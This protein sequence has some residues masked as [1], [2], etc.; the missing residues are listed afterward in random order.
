MP[1]CSAAR[2]LWSLVQFTLF[3]A[4]W[5]ARWGYFLAIVFSLTIPAQIA[6]VRRK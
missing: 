1:L 2:G 4:L 6:V 3:S 5:Q